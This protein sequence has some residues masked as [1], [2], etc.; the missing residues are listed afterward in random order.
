MTC[1]YYPARLIYSEVLDPDLENKDVEHRC[2]VPLSAHL[3]VRYLLFFWYRKRRFVHPVYLR[4]SLASSR[5]LLIHWISCKIPGCSFSSF[6]QRR[7]QTYAALSSSKAIGAYG[8]TTPARMYFPCVCIPAEAVW[9]TRREPSSAVRAE[10]SSNILKSNLATPLRSAESSV[11]QKHG[12]TELMTIE[13]SVVLAESMVAH[14]FL[15]I[16]N[17]SSFERLYLDGTILVRMISDLGRE[18]R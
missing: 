1:P 16:Y 8:C 6:P 3:E 5:K 4:K 9:T 15:M 12:S 18:W 10:I 11:L 17:C 7:S 14:S 2:G 13:S